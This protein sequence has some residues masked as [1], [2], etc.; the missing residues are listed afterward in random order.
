[1]LERGDQPIARRPKLGVNEVDDGVGGLPARPE[2]EHCF[3]SLRGLTFDDFAYLSHESK[4]I[5]AQGV[6][7]GDDMH[8][9]FLSRRGSAVD[10]DIV[11]A[12][13]GCGIC[14]V[15]AEGDQPTSTGVTNLIVDRLSVAVGDVTDSVAIPPV[16]HVGYLTGQSACQTFVAARFTGGQPPGPEF[17]RALRRRIALIEVDAGLFGIQ[18]L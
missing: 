2:Q 8:R 3:D 1:M 11:G 13:I 4:P 7:S 10:P 12:V 16:S 17:T 6:F 18:T 9:R 5:P 15:N 14:R